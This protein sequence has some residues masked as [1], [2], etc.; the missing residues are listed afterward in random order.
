MRATDTL[1]NTTT[2]PNLVSVVFQIETTP[3]PPPSIIGPPSDPSTNLSPEFTLADSEANLSFYC[4]MDGGA[5]VHCNGDTDHDGDPGV[6]AEWQYENL[7]PGPHCFSAYTVDGAGNQGASTKFCWTVIGKPASITV[8]SGSPQSTT[9]HTAFAAPLVAKVSDSLGDRGPGRE[10]HLQRPG[11]GA[12]GSFASSAGG[13]PGSNQCRVTTNSTGLATSSTFTANTTAGG[14]YTVAATTSGVSGSASFSLTNNPG[15]TT[16]LVI[17][18]SPVSGQAANKAN[19]GPITV[20]VE[21]ASNNPVNLTTATTVT[22]SSSSTGSYIFSKSQNATS[23][24]G[25]TTVTIASGSSS[26]SFYYGDTKAGSPTITATS[27]S[28][29]K[30]TQQETIT[31]GAAVISILSGNNQSA[32]QGNGFAAALVVEV[33]DLFNNPVSGATVTFTAPTTG[34]SGTFSNSSNT[35]SVTTNTSGQASETCTA[36]N[37]GGSYNVSATAGTNT[38]SFSLLNGMNFSITGPSGLAPVWPGGASRPLNLSLTNPN[39]EP[40]TIAAGAITGQVASIANASTNKS[41]LACVTSWFSISAGPAVAVTVPANTTES[42]S[43]LGLTSAQ[44]PVLKM[45][46]TG[47][48]QDNCE[49]ATLHLR[50]SGT[51]SGT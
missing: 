4:L 19:L 35:I 31:P 40:I 17:T 24:T 11:S 30:A 50:F 42:L 26:A 10:R 46:E 37:T 21:N 32:T 5:P 27:G 39:P 12:S 38:V 29:P 25:Q 13:N 1:N 23:P 9:V 44:W 7:V 43:Q 33:A 41:P 45:T 14:P 34:A 48:N 16:K 28:L 51:A 2:N 49:G 18:S 36:N 3:P 47:T 22:L 15:T 8:S 6:Q 20:T